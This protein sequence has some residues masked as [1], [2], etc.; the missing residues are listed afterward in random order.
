M[1]SRAHTASRAQ[2]ARVTLFYSDVSGFSALTERLGDALAFEVMSD[3]MALLRGLAAEHGGREV[4][5]RG[6]A[7]LLTFESADSGLDFAVAVQRALA[8]RRREAPERTVA[9][10]IGLHVG[11]P[12]AHAEGYFG[13]DVIVAARL[14]DACPTNG[15]LVSR[16][17][18][19]RLREPSRIGRVRRVTL[20]GLEEP[21]PAA[22]VYWGARPGRRPARGPLEQLARAVVSVCAG[23][24]G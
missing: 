11:R 22:R 19:R 2:P 17:L 20:K 8:A 18:E 15:I 21:E 14:A 5:V 3:F 1:S 13:R 12:I 16:S 7:C 9:L 23:R 6:D 24:F 4:E 10:R